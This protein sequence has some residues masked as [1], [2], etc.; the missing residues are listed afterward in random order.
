MMQRVVQH[1]LY[2]PRTRERRPGIGLDAIQILCLVAAISF[3]WL[4]VAKPS[5]ERTAAVVD[6]RRAA[7]RAFEGLARDV[8][9]VRGVGLSSEDLHVLFAERVAALRHTWSEAMIAS[10]LRPALRECVGG[11]VLVLEAPPTQVVSVR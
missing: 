10:P 2:R 8:D 4:G 7:V 6:S 5:L 1:E 3:A 11:P 9:R